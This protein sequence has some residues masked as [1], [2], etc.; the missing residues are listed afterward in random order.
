MLSDG[1]FMQMA[2]VVADA[3]TCS[4]LKVGA[5]LVY[6][7]RIISTGY[8][9][10]PSG[11]P[12]CVHD[13]RVP[14][15]GTCEIS[16]HAEANAVAFAARYGIATEGSTMYVT[17]SPCLNCARL[18]INAGVKEVIY[19]REYRDA[20]GVGELA[21]AGV[22]VN[23]PYGFPMRT[24]PDTQRDF[25]SVHTREHAD[26]QTFDSGRADTSA[27]YRRGTGV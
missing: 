27:D 11:M 16:V 6:A 2:E 25:Q 3:G 14:Q 19:G 9:G 20:R 1:H 26:P 15:E 17:D 18:I 22:E 21:L 5:L 4:R 10:A 13:G 12:H 23:G 7:R 8:N 24:V